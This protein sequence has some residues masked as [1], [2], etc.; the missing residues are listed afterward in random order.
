MADARHPASARTCWPTSR[1][2]C[3]CWRTR[4]IWRACPRRCARPRRR[5]LPSA[6]TRAS[7]PSRCRARASSRSC[8]SRRAATCARRRS[9]PGSARGANGGKT[10]NRKIIAEILALRAERAQAAG[11]RDVRRRSRSSSPWPRRRPA[12]RKLL[13]EVWAPAR[14]RARPRSATSCRRRCSAEGGNFELAPWDWRYYAEKVRKAKFDVDEAEVKPYLQLDNV[15]AAAFDVAT[16][17]FGVDLHRAHRPAGLSSR[18]ARLRGD[19]R[20][21]PRRPV[22]RRLLRPALQA[23]G[24]LDVG[25]ARAGASSTATSARSSSTS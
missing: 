20:G 17:L 5:R 6:A 10:D 7:T 24:R 1:P 13:M 4:R 18:R 8:S 14:A 2:S 15:I 3:W 19:A 22:P 21:P 25:L 16:K 23:L 12:V 11:L 9:R